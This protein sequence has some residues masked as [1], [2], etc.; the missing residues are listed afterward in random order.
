MTLVVKPEQDFRIGDWVIRPMLNTIEHAQS[1]VQKVLAPKVMQ[2][3]ILLSQHHPQVVSQDEILQHIWPERVMSDSSFYQLIAQ[4]RKALDDNEPKK[5]YVERVS[6]KGYRMLQ[7]AQPAIV[8]DKPGVQDHNKCE[9]KPISAGI[10][11]RRF[12]VISLL[13]LMSFAVFLLMLKSDQQEQGL[14]DPDTAIEGQSISSLAIL[15]VQNLTSPR[16]NMLDEFNGTLLEDL[17]EIPS[18]KTIYLRQQGEDVRADVLLISNI[19]N[20]NDTLV[21]NLSL[22][23]NPQKSVIWSRQITRE[24]DDLLGLQQSAS[25]ALQRF[26]GEQESSQHSSVSAQLYED[27]L[28]ASYLLNRRDA[29]SLTQAERLFSDLILRQPDYAPALSGLCDTYTFMTIYSDMPEQAARGACQPLIEKALALRPDNGRIVATMALLT[30][31]TDLE[32]GKVLFKRAI[33]LSP[34]YANAYLWL[35][36]ALRRTGEY[37]AA[38]EQ[39]NIALSL[40]PLSPI[41]MRSLAYSYLSL[42]HVAKARRYYQR[43]LAIE[44]NYMQRPLEELDFLPLNIE[45]ARAFL[46]WVQTSR[47][48]LANQPEYKL[49][50]S[51]VWIALGDLDHAQQL[52][53]QATQADVSPAFKLYVSAA[54]ENARGNREKTYSLLQQRLNLAPEINSF[55]MPLVFAL[56]SSGKARQALNTFEMY[57]S[58]FSQRIPIDADNFQQTL[59]YRN[60][61]AKNGHPEQAEL[62]YQRLADYIDSL[63]GDNAQ[64]GLIGWLVLNG[65][66]EKAKSLM[67]KQLDSSWLPDINDNIN[68]YE[69]WLMLY[70]QSGGTALEFETKLQRNRNAVITSLTPI[71]AGE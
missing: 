29:K 7:T 10:R 20:H 71:S 43:A 36:N 16:L 25:Q 2:L 70:V 21:L 1:G 47:S 8:E 52:Y 55:V 31:Y 53:T 41:I 58:Q 23:A 27:F 39:H 11:F 49:T 61:L 59:F 63:P 4:L 22:V 69:D 65:K 57:F 6:G 26:W 35:G 15:P 60:L 33:E 45:R 40:D 51:L 44:P 5:R 62:V 14:A 34:S 56:Q 9:E 12:G 28:L 13:V 68:A 42:R 19:A 30:S 38:L 24:A 18:L 64:P 3:C 50:Q 67:D 54:I 48:N 46:N 32:E 66:L 37:Q 17:L